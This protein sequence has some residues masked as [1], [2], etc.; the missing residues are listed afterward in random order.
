MLR[1]KVKTERSIVI[2]YFCCE[3]MCKRVNGKKNILRSVLAMDKS[4]DNLLITIF[5]NIDR[6]P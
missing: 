5:Y 3:Q 4:I 1:A 6:Y 2:S